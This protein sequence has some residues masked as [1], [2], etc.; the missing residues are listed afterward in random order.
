MLYVT[1]ALLVIV[2]I[3]ALRL[4]KMKDRMCSFENIEPRIIVSAAVSKRGHWYWRAN[5]GTS[6]V[7]KEPIYR[8]HNTRQECL[9]TAR[10]LF[11][12]CSAIFVEEE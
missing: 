3:M 8:K 10:L 4:A 7:F 12:D 11:C 6:Q 2:I 5:M 1:L 9:A